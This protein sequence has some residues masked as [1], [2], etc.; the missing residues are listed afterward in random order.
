MSRHIVVIAV[1]INYKNTNPKVTDA[2]IARA[3]TKVSRIPYTFGL[4]EVKFLLSLNSSL[5]F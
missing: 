4:A 1:E 2:Q 3:Y 5:K